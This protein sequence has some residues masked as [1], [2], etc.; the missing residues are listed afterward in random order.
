MT[1]DVTELAGPVEEEDGK[2]VLRVP[3]VDGGDEFA[4]VAEDFSQL[5]GPDLKITLPDWLVK[6]LDLREG[7]RVAIDNRGRK[8]NVTLVN[9]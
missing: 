4:H 7:S 6:K 2:L 9:R 3:L 8:F 1:S 5:D